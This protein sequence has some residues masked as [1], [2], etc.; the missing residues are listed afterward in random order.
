MTIR[1]KRSV[2]TA[3]LACLALVLA[4]CSSSSSSGSSPASG[5]VAAA[6]TVDVN[7]G[8]GTPVKLPKGPLKIG[9]FMNS[10]SNQW[11]L[12]VAHTA[13][14]TAQS[15][16]WTAT[17]QGFNFDQ[18]AM[19]N[20]L[21]LAITNHTYNAIAVVPIDGNGSCNILTKT[22]PQQ[23]VLVVVGG[24]PLCGRDAQH[25]N[26]MW[27]PGT[28]AYTQVAPSYDYA[29]LFIKK[30]SELF[31]G[32][33]NV[34][35]VVGPPLNGN[36]IVM[37]D[38][39]IQWAQTDPQFHITNFITTDYTTPVTYSAVQTYLQAHSNTT[40]LL[41][42]YSPDMSRGVVD[43]L[44]SLHLVGKVKVAD[45]GGASYSI[46]EIKAGA[47]QLTMP[48]YPISTGKNMILAIRDA[49]EGKPLGHVIEEIPGGL[50]NAPVITKSNVNSFTPQY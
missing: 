34:A 17:I 41:S 27:S 9:I 45:M 15:F 6:G 37:H 24:V 14:Q 48:Y 32:P 22:A 21:Q 30:A 23:N 43:A 4:A 28:L 13:Q 47:I 40:V 1:F 8:T 7:V 50:S 25:V 10:Q 20:A 31:P 46:G 2:V 3:V 18:Q 19:Q 5:S 44:Q 39:A 38:L 35:I 16:G 29:N 26:G 11:Q 42:V 49:Q 12:N 36:T 33:Q